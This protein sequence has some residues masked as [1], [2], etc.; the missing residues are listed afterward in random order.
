MLVW[1]SVT[2]GSRYSLLALAELDV[3]LAPGLGGGEHA[4]GATHVTERGLTGTVGTTTRD[5]GDT[6]DSA[7]W[8]CMLALRP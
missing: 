8:I 1:L 6:G 2:R 3:P 4:A 7:T 5:T